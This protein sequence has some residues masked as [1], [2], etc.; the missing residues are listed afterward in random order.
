M[1]KL[2][3]VALLFGLVLALVPARHA[4]A[5]DMQMAVLL[6]PPGDMLARAY[7]PNLSGDAGTV[8]KEQRAEAKPAAGSETHWKELLSEDEDSHTF[9]VIFGKS[10]LFKSFT[11]KRI[12][13][14]TD[15]EDAAGFK[16]RADQN[17]CGTIETRWAPANKGIET[18][19][20]FFA[21]SPL[22]LD[23]DAFVR[24]SVLY[25]EPLPTLP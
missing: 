22:L 14:A 13:T 9:N 20:T 4:S 7:T 16:S 10:W 19:A 17:R 25:G 24:M 11:Y 15:P 12:P 8:G 18:A 21:G 3:P 6:I 5:D 2:F 23:R 1:R